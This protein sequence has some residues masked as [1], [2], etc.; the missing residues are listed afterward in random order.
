M[1]YI[2]PNTFSI[3]TFN[4]VVGKTLMQTRKDSSKKSTNSMCFLLRKLNINV[5]LLK[6]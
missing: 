4:E 5:K 3:N 2:A 1:P 6:S